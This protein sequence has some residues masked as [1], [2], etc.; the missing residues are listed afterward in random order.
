MV[1]GGYWKLTTDV[2]APIAVLFSVDELGSAADARVPLCAALLAM[3]RHF[4][5]KIVDR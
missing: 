4:V 2:V 1:L 5:P 3:V